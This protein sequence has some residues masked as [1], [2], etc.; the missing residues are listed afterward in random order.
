[1]LVSAGVASTRAEAAERCRLAIDSGQ[2]VEK[3]RAIIER[4]GGDPRV[5]DDYNRLPRAPEAHVVRA[6]MAG[7]VTALDAG[8]IGRA[9]V[10]LGGGRDT[11]DEAI[12]PGVG[13]IIRATVGEAVQ[14]GDAVLELHYRETAR[15]QAALPL[16]AL[17]VQVAEQ[18]PP[19]RALIIEEV[20]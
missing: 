1:M 3:F 19:V 13:V 14:H 18:P 4:Q 5:I 12:D 7:F 9:S 8:L 11:V 17:A 6:P 2:A 16:V 10:A 20:L 15:L